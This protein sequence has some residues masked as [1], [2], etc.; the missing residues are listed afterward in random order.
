MRARTGGGRSDV[1]W[2]LLARGGSRAGGF[3]LVIAIISVGGDDVFCFEDGK[4]GWHGSQGASG[5]FA[6]I[7]GSLVEAKVD[8]LSRIV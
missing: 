3:V 2:R 5:L 4:F 1:S 6:S 7:N 8:D